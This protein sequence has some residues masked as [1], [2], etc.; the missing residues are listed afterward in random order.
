MSKLHE[1]SVELSTLAVFRNLLKDEVVSA[2]QDL[3][4]AVSASESKDTTINLY[5]D[6]VSK[7]F[8]H[9]HC[10]SQ[11]ITDLV[12]NDENFYVVGK[13]FGQ[14]FDNLIESCL[15]NEL[16]VLAKVAELPSTT[17]RENLGYYGFLP[18]WSTEPVDLS[19]IF[20]QHVEQLSTKG[21]GIYSKYYAFVLTSQGV[22]PIKNP[23]PQKLSELP[24]YERERELV[25]KNTLS[26]L[27][28]G[29]VNNVLLY[30]DAGTG[31]SSTV[32]AILNE[33][34]DQGLRLIEIKKE[35]LMNLPDLLET[36]ARNP[37]KFILFIDDLSFSG[38]DDN[39]TALK[40]ILEGSI[41]CR[42]KN[43][44]LYATSNRKH[45]M[46][47]NMSDRNGDD[48]HLNDTIQE[49]LSL[50]ARFGLTVTFQTPD[51][52]D[53]LDIVKHLAEEYKLTLAE[54]ELFIKAEAFAIRNGGRSPRTAKH[55]V[56]VQAVL[57]V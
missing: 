42:S 44:A 36:L 6:L 14:T 26:L 24:G 31:K 50:S 53:F 29:E 13:G 7:L 39:F 43:V 46:K 3:C 40:A 9:T 49:N 30:G 56:Q 15:A 47:E 38:N 10:L 11:Y 48:L 22:M 17:V 2:L 19:T 18:A 20:K 34:K 32:K 5:G 35:Q 57:K 21:Y 4:V 28:G 55:F 37:L 51:K 25:I 33:Y 12:L 8:N 1:L 45:L 16:K 41:A 27:S 54:E 52:D 23:D